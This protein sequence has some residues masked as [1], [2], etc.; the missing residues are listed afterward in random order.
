MNIAPRRQH[1]GRAD[2]ITT[3]HGCDV[4]GRKRAHQPAQLC[5]LTQQVLDPNP[6]FRVGFCHHAQMLLQLCLGHRAAHHMQ[7]VGDQ[8][9]LGLE[10]RQPQPVGVAFGQVNGFGLCF[11]QPGQIGTLMRIWRQT[12]PARQA[13][14][15]FRQPLVKPSRR[16]GRRQMGDGH[17]V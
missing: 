1:L 6:R 3:R 15:E 2:Q 11:D 14:L 16:Q 13:V 10:Q 17:S 5:L 12:T 8:R 4:T 9:I 7:A